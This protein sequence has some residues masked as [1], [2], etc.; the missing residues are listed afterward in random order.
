MI[1]NNEPSCRTLRNGSWEQSFRRIISNNASWESLRVLESCCKYI[2]TAVQSSLESLFET[3][4][5]N[6]QGFFRRSLPKNDSE[7]LFL[8]MLLKNSS[9]WLFRMIVGNN[10]SEQSL[11]APR[12]HF[13]WLFLTI[14]QNNCPKGLSWTIVHNSAGDFVLRRNCSEQS[15]RGLLRG[16]P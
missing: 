9:E 11:R 16:P 14:V 4:L 6:P 15:L 13:E 1:L 8:G 3:I 7:E 10:T 12:D 5:K 2:S